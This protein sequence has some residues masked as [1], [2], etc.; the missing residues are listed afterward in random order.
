MPF[1]NVPKDLNRV[2][3]KVALNLTKRQ[4]VCF[5]CA[6]AIGVPLFLLTR[7]PLG[8]QGSVL[9][10]MTVMLPFFFLGMYEKDGQPAERIL[11]NWLRA[12]IWPSHR[13]YKTENLYNYLQ[14]EGEAYAKQERDAEKQQRQNEKSAPKRKAT[15]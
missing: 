1:V 15:R 5:G 3:T 8:S 13:P 6:A 4:L 2:K 11:R 14:K 7:T 12:H 9:L 10:M